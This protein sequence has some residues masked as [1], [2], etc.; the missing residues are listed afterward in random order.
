M[1]LLVLLRILMFGLAVPGIV[2]CVDRVDQ[3]QPAVV[4]Y[5][6]ASLCP[7]GT[8]WEKADD[9]VAQT[10]GEVVGRD[11]SE[12]CTTDSNGHSSC[13]RHYSV[14]VR[15][16]ERSQELGVAYRTYRTADRGDRAELRLWQGEVVRMVTEGHTETFLTSSEFALGGW[17]LFGW[18]L[19]A[20]SWLALFGL[21]LYPLL[22][23]WLLLTVPYVMVATNH[24]GINPMGTTGWSVAA[25]LT[26]VGL[27]L[28]G[29]SLVEALSWR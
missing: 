23:G 5:R 13:T 2:L 1:V 3:H 10:T 9:C 6:N 29:R 17:L 4:M 18:L 14:T 20:A 16:G 28:V 7:A 15:F 19:L 22:G 12:S 21:W 11:W 25:L 8:P 27:W 24:L 26:A